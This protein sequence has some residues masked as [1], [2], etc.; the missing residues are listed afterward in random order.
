VEVIEQL[1]QLGFSQYEAQA[2]V[3]L[4]KKNPLNGY[5]LAKASGI[6]RPNIYPV[7]QKLEESGAAMRLATAEGTRYVPV[8]AEELLAK[9]KNRYQRLVDAASASLEPIAAPPALAA[10]LNVR[11][12]DE[13]LE[14]AGLLLE[15]TK[16]HLLISLWPEEAAKLAEPLHQ[17][18]ERGVDI[19]TLC[20]R[21]CPRPCPACRGEV[22]RYALAPAAQARWLVLVSDQKELLAGEITEPGNT[23]AAV[24]TCQQMLVNLTG[25]YIQNSIALATIL[26]NIGGQQLAE[27]NPETIAALNHLR[28]FQDK[29][30]W[31]EAMQRAVHQD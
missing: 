16:S 26:K 9:L 7:L 21:G 1:K 14:Q 24:R 30:T 29:G 4:L 31:L 23:A 8:Q 20:L 6:P 2:Y 3:A 22:Y 27:E 17:A 13:L 12:Y 28:P 18:L 15:R 25:S 10:V 5:E 19:T 11:G